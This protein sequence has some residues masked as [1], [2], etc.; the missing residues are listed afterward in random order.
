[1]TDTADA[2][3]RWIEARVSVPIDHPEYAI[4]LAGLMAG[5][6]TLLADN[7]PGVEAYMRHRM[8]YDHTPVRR[9]PS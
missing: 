5:Q 9:T 7:V 8:T 3:R 6:L 2:Y 1:M 4:R